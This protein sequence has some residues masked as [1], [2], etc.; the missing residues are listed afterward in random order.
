MTKYV[1]VSAKYALVPLGFTK[2][3]TVMITVC[4]LQ[5]IGKVM[6]VCNF[7]QLTIRKYQTSAWPDENA[8]K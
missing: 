1:K 3:F 4:M 5:V 7:V 8:I 6:H 2:I